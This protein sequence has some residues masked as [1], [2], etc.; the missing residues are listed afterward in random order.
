M[1]VLVC[2][3]FFISLGALLALGLC[4]SFSLVRPHARVW[5]PPGRHSWQLHLVWWLTVVSTAGIVLS[6]ILDWNSGPLGHWLRLPVGAALVLGGLLLALAGI[7][8]LGRHA[9]L[10][11]EGTLIETGPYRWTR[12]P[13]YVGDM[14]TLLGWAMICNSGR[15]SWLAMLAIACFALTPFTEEPWLREQYG[16]A[17]EAYRSRVA[18][19]LG[20]PRRR[21]MARPESVET[22]S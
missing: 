15:T 1:H 12:N 8:T 14:A 5:P 21:L 13:Q 9:T 16:E 19:F 18:R 10:G 4:L 11:L 3:A 22:K 20:R 6:G 2:I 7:N 17:Y